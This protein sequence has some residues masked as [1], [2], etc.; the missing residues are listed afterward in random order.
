MHVDPSSKAVACLSSL[1]R[2]QEATIAEVRGNTQLA[3]RLREFGFLRGTPVR[4]LRVGSVLM[5]QLGELRLCLRR[6]DAAAIMVEPVPACAPR[7]ALD[8]A[9]ATLEPALAH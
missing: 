8:R 2:G 5:M 9:A 1:S 6:R 3:T 7:P 4:V